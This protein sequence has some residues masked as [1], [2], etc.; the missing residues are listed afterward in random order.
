MT[1]SCDHGAEKK[2]ATLHWN[3]PFMADTQLQW[4]T[5]SDL[6]E[7]AKK[8]K[9]KKTIQVITAIAVLFTLP[10]DHCVSWQSNNWQHTG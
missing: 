6:Q 4:A 1:Q 2:D 7:H 9:K 8:K 10:S 3:V 5:L